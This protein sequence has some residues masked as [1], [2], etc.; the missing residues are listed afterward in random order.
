MVS[1]THYSLLANSAV[2]RSWDLSDH[3]PIYSFLKRGIHNNLNLSQPQQN[4]L[5]L[6][7]KKV[8]ENAPAIA[9]HNMWSVLAEDPERGEEGVDTE[10]LVD[11]S[12]EA[13]TSV[14]LATEVVL[15][16]AA[17]H[18][19]PRPPLTRDSRRMVRARR[20]A[21]A[22]WERAPCGSEEKESLWTT[23]SK[24]KKR[25]RDLIQ[26]EQKES[27]SNF[28][29]KGAELLASGLGKMAWQWIK[30]ITQKSTA[31]SLAP[32]PVKDLDGNLQVEPDGIANALA[33]HYASLASDAT[34]HSRDPAHWQEMGT[35]QRELNGAIRAM[36]NGK[37]PG[38][39]GLPPEWFKA[40]AENPSVVGN[41]PSTPMG[42]A[43]LKVIQTIWY[44][45]SVPAC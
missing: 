5:R 30:T 13:S 16:P 40:M 19:K 43:F 31:R 26:K 22:K 42:K 10:A 21:F 44:N 38:L 35:S 18:R 24:L 27:W 1:S 20:K 8:S 34:L 32:Q 33:A 2:N 14:A 3:W 12:L 23:Y 9:C 39:D 15:Q 36:K 28:I 17:P 29:A 37:A 45:A 4:L 41:E 6:D 7:R 25:T 11:K